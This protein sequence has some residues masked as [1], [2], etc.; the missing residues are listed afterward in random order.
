MNMNLS[1]DENEAARQLISELENRSRRWPWLRWVG[2]TVSIIVLFSSILL[3]RVSQ[4]MQDEIDAVL[5]NRE[6]SADNFNPEY[7]NF[8]ID[9]S[10]SRN[11]AKEYFENAQAI[12]FIGSLAYLIY[13]FANR[14]RGVRAGL[15]AKLLRQTLGKDTVTGRGKT[16]TE[17]KPEGNDLKPAP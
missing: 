1:K 14:N 5:P 16:S 11:A 4:R 12:A 17:P 15:L 7:V 6:L 9:Y 13:F 3:G 2:I 8:Y 10:I